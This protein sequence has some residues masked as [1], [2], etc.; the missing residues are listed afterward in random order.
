M[1]VADL[2]YV[3]LVTA[4]G[5]T[6]FGAVAA[7]LAGWRGDPGLRESARRSVVATAVLISLA[8]LTLIRGFVTDDFSIR[9]VAE[10]SSRDQPWYYTL[11]A[12]YG[13]QA[14]SLLFWAWTLAL[15]SVVV[16]SR[17]EERERHFRPYVTG[18]LLGIQVFFLSLLCFLSNPLE[19]VPFPLLDGRGLNPLLKDPGMLIHPPLLLGGYMSFSVPYAYTVAALLTGRVGVDW[20]QS[21]RR[22][23]LL[24]WTIQSMGL[25]MGA[26]WAYRVL[27]WGGYWG[28]DPVENVA[29]LPWLT[30]T[31]FLHSILVQEQRS[32]LKVW[33][34]SLAIA[35]FALAIFGTFVVR[36]GIITSVHSFAFSSI[37]PA[38]LG[39]L[40]FVLVVSLALL[41]ARLPRLRSAGAFHSVLSREVAF[42]VN[43][44][45]FVGI[46]FATFWGTIFPLVSEAL[47]NE[48]TTVGPPFFNQVNG[49]LFLAL[50]VLMGVGPLL[51]WGRTAPGTLFRS[52]RAPVVASA[53]VAGLLWL[54]GLQKLGSIAG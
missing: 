26:W 51:A 9:Y 12:F 46:A 15:L 22:W 3:A 5:V 20:T 54:A 13:S 49:P 44:L 17:R 52:A 53:L 25:L 50:M 16:V 34:V 47:W 36:S 10:N 8:S 18:V 48:K 43:N 24:S 45:L 21:I 27:G 37:G 7:F 29:L 11:A 32:M 38:F 30:S 40:A 42:L 1:S 33:N 28:W 19:Q 6:V 14:G 2:G 35:T 31:A 41:F 39:F 23:T 4:L